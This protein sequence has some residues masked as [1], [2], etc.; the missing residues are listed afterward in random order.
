MRRQAAPW[1][2]WYLL[3]F[4]DALAGSGPA[5]CRAFALWPQ[6]QGGHGAHWKAIQSLSGPTAIPAT[7]AASLELPRLRLGLSVNQPPLSPNI[8]EP[9]SQQDA[10]PW[11]QNPKSGQRL[12][13]G[14]N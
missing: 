13:G 2:G 12:F 7:Q 1:G 6:P 5:L 9:N 4:D 3:G 10:Q 8:S 14:A 11:P